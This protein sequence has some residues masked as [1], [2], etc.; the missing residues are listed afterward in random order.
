MKKYDIDRYLDNKN[1]VEKKI[2]EF[3]KD[4]VIVKE[5]SP[6]EIKGHMLKAS[7]NL[8]FIKKISKTEFKDWA[9]TGCYYAS[10]H[11]ALALIMTRGYSSKNHLATFLIIVKEFY[12]KGLEKE[13]IEV[14]S[15]ML[16]Y[17]DILFYVEFKNKREDASYSTNLLFDK[18]DVEELRIK[19][20]LFVSKIRSIIRNNS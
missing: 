9:V 2:N 15:D 17:E 4:K 10:Y 11:A 5:T 16:D 8:E 12:K 13:D 7:H 14:F 20:V 3:I 6:S 19:A 18:K 1:L